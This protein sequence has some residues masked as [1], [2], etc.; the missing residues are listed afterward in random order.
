MKNV[1]VKITVWLHIC[2]MHLDKTLLLSGQAILFTKVYFILYFSTY[3]NYN[4]KLNCNFWPVTH[5]YYWDLLQAFFQSNLNKQKPAFINQEFTSKVR[6]AW[7]LLISIRNLF[8]IKFK[9]SINSVFDANQSLLTSS[10][11]IKLWLKWC[12]DVLA[13]FETRYQWVTIPPIDI[14]TIIERSHQP[15]T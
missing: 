14:Y 7:K 6:N 3:K 13:L 8:V 9:L 4:K 12:S 11:Q 2:L 5:H 10:N 15:S 1:P